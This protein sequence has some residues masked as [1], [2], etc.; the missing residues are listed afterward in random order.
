MDAPNPYCKR[1]RA[2]K[3]HTKNKRNRRER[4]QARELLDTAYRQYLAT[5][6]YP[7]A[8][9]PSASSEWNSVVESLS[10]DDLNNNLENI[11]NTNSNQI[12]NNTNLRS[13]TPP[14]STLLA[15]E[16]IS[17]SSSPSIYRIFP[18]TPESSSIFPEPSYS[19]VFLF[20]EEPRV[21]SPACSSTSNMEFLEEV[22]SL[23]FPTIYPSWSHIYSSEIPF[24][25]APFTDS[26]SEGLFR[27]KLRKT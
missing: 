21:P 11:N 8:T 10:P 26:I 6:N 1:H 3:K 17:P 27:I 15:I 2:G 13:D 9:I 19:P 20:E 7:R 16:T 23:S 12:D 14:H 25:F 4:E 24:Y 18:N 22:P 5:L